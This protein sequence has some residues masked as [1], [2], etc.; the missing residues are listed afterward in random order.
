M[1]SFGELKELARESAWQELQ[2]LAHSVKG[3]A[4]Q[5]GATRIT[6]IAS[7]LES[8]TKAVVS[9]AQVDEE[10]IAAL[11]ERLSSAADAT[12]DYLVKASL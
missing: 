12:L 3:A 4:A 1:K 7:E 10:K 2:D 8:F 11:L 5:V 9:S 6:T